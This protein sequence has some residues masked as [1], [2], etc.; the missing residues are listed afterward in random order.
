MPATVV[1]RLMSHCPNDLARAAHVLRVP[2]LERFK[3][4]LR[5]GLL[6][7]VSVQGA[8]LQPSDWLRRVRLHVLIVAFACKST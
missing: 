1:I 3:P 8:Y 4:S 5:V 6:A 2:V 7:P